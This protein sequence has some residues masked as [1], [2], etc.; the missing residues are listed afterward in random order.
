MT[1]T[2]PQIVQGETA[3]TQTADPVAERRAD[4]IAK[5]AGIAEVLQELRRDGMLLLEPENVAWMTSG[6]SPSGILGPDE[7]PAVLLSAEQ[8]WLVCANV[9]SQ[10]FFDEE[11]TG[12]GFQLK[13]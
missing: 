10:R 13:E 9:D 4:I 11:L 8:R 2:T 3:P 5:Q 1:E 7:M 6:A 12:L